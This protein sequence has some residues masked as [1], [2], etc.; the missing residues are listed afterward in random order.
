VVEVRDNGLGVPEAKRRISS[1]LFSGARGYQRRDRWTGLGLSIVHD[2]VSLSAGELGGF[3]RGWNDVSVQHAEPPRGDEKPADVP[4][5]PA[6]PVMLSAD[7]T[8]R[9]R[10]AKAEMPPLL[11]VVHES[12]ALHRGFQ[13]L[14]VRRRSPDAFAV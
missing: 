8:Q 3:P 2:T 5:F 6:S 9:I 11:V 4:T 13:L 10:Q 1:A 14:S 12:L 7:R